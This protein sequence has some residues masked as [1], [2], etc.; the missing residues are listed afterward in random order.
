MLQNEQKI[1]E[2]IRT[3]DSKALALLFNNTIDRLYQFGI[4]FTDDN[5]IV[6]DCIQELFIKLHTNHANLPAVNNPLFYLFRSLKNKLIDMLQQKEKLVF[7]PTHELPFLLK[8]TYDNPEEEKDEDIKEKFEKA[9]SLLS[10]RQKEAV[11]L[12]FQ[13]EMSYDEIS[14]ILNINYQS[15]RNLI[16]RAIEKIR[17]EINLKLFISILVNI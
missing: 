8:L 12:R 16:H 14:V 3:G 1:W 10:D 2:Q 11:Y 7:F 4:K 5:E 17:T 6:K 9:I 13:A 15:A